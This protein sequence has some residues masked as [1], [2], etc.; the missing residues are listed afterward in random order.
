[1]Y[2]LERRVPKEAG[3]TGSSTPNAD[4]ALRWSGCAWAWVV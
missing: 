2:V 4:G 3:A 1:M